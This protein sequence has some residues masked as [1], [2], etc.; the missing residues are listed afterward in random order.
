MPEATKTKRE[1]RREDTANE[2][3]AVA[4]RQMAE[5]G[6]AGL[7]LRAIASEMNITAPAIYRYYEN[8]DTLITALILDGFNALADALE[9][10]RDSH[11]SPDA[12]E[13]LFAVLIAYR[14]WANANPLDFQL[15]YGNPIPGY[16]APREVTVPAVVRGF[17]VIIGLLQQLLQKHTAAVPPV[18][19]QFAAYFRAMIDRDGYPVSE[20]AFYW[21]IVSWT[22]LHGIIMLEIFNHLQ[23]TIGDVD[24]YY[25]AEIVQLI[26]EFGL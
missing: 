6:T 19:P 10:A 13:Q 16:H 14:A 24:A 11:P 1:Q 21:G 4:R 5:T 26:K 3:K 17:A 12:R 8:R 9:Q 7:S 22:R 25:H 18:P 20:T 2:I 15:I 23:P